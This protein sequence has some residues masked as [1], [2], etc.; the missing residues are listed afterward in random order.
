MSLS[1]KSYSVCYSNKSK[2]MVYAE[3]I[4]IG[5]E[6]LIG[7]IVDTNSAW[8][9]ERLNDIGIFVSQI[10]TVSDNRDHI[11]RAI[12]LAEERADIIL[13]TG[14]LGPTRD[15]ITRKTL[16][17]YFNTVL[18][19]DPG[20]L[21]CIEELLEKRAFSMNA[22]NRKQALIPTNCRP[23]PNPLGTA[24]GML[25]EESG[26]VYVSLPG[27]PFEM[28]SIMENHVLPLL[29][30]RFDT[31]FI[32]HRTLTIQGFTESTLSLVL[33]EWENTLPNGVKLAYLPSPGLIRLRLSVSG[34]EYERAQE[35]IRNHISKLNLVIPEAIVSY[36]AEGI[37]KVIGDLLKKRGMTVASAESCTGGSI[38]AL[39]T[40][41]PGSSDYFKGSVVAYSNEIKHNLLKVSMKSLMTYGAVSK[42]VVEEM[43]KGCL[44]LVKTDFAV[45][46]SGIA[47][48][49]G[50]TKEKPVGTT[51]ISVASKERI[52]SQKYVM[53]ELRSS[54]IQRSVLTALNMLRKLII[55]GSSP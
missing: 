53:G 11:K 28:K 8:M 18:V 22:L 45:A 1:I 42:A 21:K 52:F 24:P 35:K 49:G 55:E 25:F 38:A 26:K 43:A 3:L 12:K 41:I 17:E 34:T 29:K 19:E 37:E 7:Q 20:V 13:I 48:P 14:G 32:I 23:L 39:I 50:G 46:T 4:V 54:N 36:E 33:E 2:M 15:D 47:G 40:S 10:S 44:R 27:V 16:A 30:G 51:W 9:A 6:I 31:P 5:D